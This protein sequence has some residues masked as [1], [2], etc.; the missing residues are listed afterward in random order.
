MSNTNDN[1][2]FLG[3]PKSGKTT[4]LALMAQHLQDAANRSSKLNFRSL[5]TRVLNQQAGKVCEEEITTQFIDDCIFRLRQQAWPVKTQGYEQGY[6]FE[7]KIYPRFFGISLYYRS[8]VIDYHDYP[9]EAFEVAFG[10]GDEPS[11]RMQQIGLDLKKRISTAR[12]I[13]L[14]IDTDN[15]FNGVDALK[16][17]EILTKLFRYIHSSNPQIKLAVIFNKLELFDGKEPDFVRKFRSEFSNAYAYLPPSHK[18]FN[19]YPLGKVVTTEDGNII[20]PR[21]LQPRNILD[22]VRWMFGF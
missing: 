16:H 15:V 3:L 18:F 8:A 6:S 1:Y 12:G 11:P 10:V 20:P 17:R 19:V 14:I 13:F 22:P 4:Y 2:L 9:G 21:P 7:L 5:A